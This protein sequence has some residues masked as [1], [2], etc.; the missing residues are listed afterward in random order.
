MIFDEELREQVARVNEEARDIRAES[1]RHGELPQWDLVE[2]DLLAPLGE[3]INAIETEIAKRDDSQALAPVDREPVPDRFQETVRR[4]YERLGG[5]DAPTSAD[6]S[7]QPQPEAEI[8][9]AR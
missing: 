3:L 6:V 2:S 8:N 7:A 4:Y 9:D 5:V 1:R